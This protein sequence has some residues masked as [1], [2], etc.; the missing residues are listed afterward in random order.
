MWNYVRRAAP[1]FG[2]IGA[3]I[4]WF[5]TTSIPDTVS[6]ADSILVTNL[7]WLGWDEPPT[8]L[9]TRFANDIFR[10]VGAALV[11]ICLIVL[12]IWGMER[13]SGDGRKSNQSKV[14]GDVPRRGGIVAH[15]RFRGFDGFDLHMS[16]NSGAFAHNIVTGYDSVRIQDDGANNLVMSNAFSRGEMS[17][18]DIPK[19]P[20]GSSDLWRTSQI[21]QLLVEQ[22]KGKTGTICERGSV[23]S[24]DA[25]DFMNKEL[26]LRGEIWL[27]D[28]E[29]QVRL[30]YQKT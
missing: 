21:V 16:G 11:L 4:F 26:K 20:D 30:G 14:T 13:M 1:I 25:R 6:S 19:L 18:W 12:V 28:D 27:I 22:W 5:A 10:L 17:P 7:K 8:G 29:L 3:G 23:L 2:I 24:P 9:A 15:N